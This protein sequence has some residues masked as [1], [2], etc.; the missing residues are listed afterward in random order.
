MIL[1]IKGML[2]LNRASGTVLCESG[3]GRHRESGKSVGGT[4]GMYSSHR[5]S[6]I[7]LGF[8]F[9]ALRMMS[10]GLPSSNVYNSS[11]NRGSQH[12]EAL[13]LCTAFCSM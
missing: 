3:S 8:K 10:R 5:N 1:F 6:I 12:A 13:C 9:S 11:K 7:Q 4:R 2:R